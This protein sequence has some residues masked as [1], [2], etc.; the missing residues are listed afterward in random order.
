MMQQLSL[1]P[2]PLPPHPVRKQWKPGPF[3]GW[4]GPVYEASSISTCLTL[5]NCE[6]PDTTPSKMNSPAQRWISPNTS[7]AGRPKT[8]RISPK[9]MAK[10]GKILPLIMAPSTPRVMSHHS[11]AF[12]LEMEVKR[13]ARNQ[14]QYN[15][16]VK[17]F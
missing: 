11:F 2:R 1:V 13:E 14:K 6:S 17:T 16:K 5:E 9:K 3:S 7:S 4:E 8:S 10:R 15:Q 12:I